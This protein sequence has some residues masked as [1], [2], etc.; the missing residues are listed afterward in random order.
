MKISTSDMALAARHEAWQSR[1]TETR[2]SAWVD[3][4]QGPGGTRPGF[5]IDMVERSRIEVSS[6]GRSLLA[7]S[8]SLAPE[9]SARRERPAAA[10]AE[11]TASAPEASKPIAEDV[12]PTQLRL[13]KDLVEAMTGRTLQVFSS[14]A[15][16]GQ[17]P[18]ETTAPPP[19]GDT[20]APDNAPEQR[21]GWGIEI[22]HTEINE[23]YERSDFA[24]SGRVR[25]EDGRELK[26]D[27]MLS[28]EHYERE[29]TNI[30]ISAGDPRMKDPLILNLDS[31]TPSATGETIRFDLI[32]GGT[33]E[34]LPVLRGAAYLALDGDG[35][36]RIDSGKELFGPQTDD[37]FAEL[38]SLD[39]DGN[40]WIDE[41][42]AA[43]SQL[44]LWRPDPGGVGSLQSLA[45][46]G[47]GA[48]YLG[49]VDTPFTLRTSE[50][51]VAAA[52]R[53]SGV[54]LTESGEV[55]ALQ[56]IDVAV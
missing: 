51:S 34:R 6:A 21:V 44:R 17:A 45:D 29:E 2:T 55:G 49:K 32:E 39:Q 53:S 50:G 37:G 14:S 26:F 47:V 43:F 7:R 38:A 22:D 23:R 3:P 48:L 31:A 12:L 27:F 56:Q 9:M 10:A 18:A 1:E 41:S 16:S 42:D 52:V 35:N 24:A 40:G 20:A 28:M 5:A 4:R 15:L 19:P 46:A 25:L 13:L 36:G 54:F 11:Q 33:D 30:S 8:Q